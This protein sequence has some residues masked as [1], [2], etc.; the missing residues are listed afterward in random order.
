MPCPTRLRNISPACF[1][2]SFLNAWATSS[3]IR[4]SNSSLP[5]RTRSSSRESSRCRIATSS[6]SKRAGS[7]RS[8]RLYRLETTSSFFL[9]L[10]FRSAFLESFLTLSNSFRNFSTSTSFPIRKE[11]SSRSSLRRVTAVS[12]AGS[13]S[14]VCST[15]RM[16]SCR[17]TS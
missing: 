13:P 6:A 17:L 7:P 3:L 2:S 5:I 16:R 9:L 1:N 4:S 12:F 15:K 8:K 10:Y 14:R 11:G